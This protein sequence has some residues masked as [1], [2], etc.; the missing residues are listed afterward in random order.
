VDISNS[1]GSTD[2]SPEACRELGKECRE[3][4]SNSASL[5]ALLCPTLD[6]VSAQSM[7][8]RMYISPGCV[9][10]SRVFVRVYLAETDSEV[11]VIA[12][13]PMGIAT[14]PFGR[15]AVTA[16]FA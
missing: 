5:I 2:A 1:F 16:A 3:C 8:F 11:E 7:F 13:R 10:M 9:N 4:V 6:A 15:P 12:P 14:S